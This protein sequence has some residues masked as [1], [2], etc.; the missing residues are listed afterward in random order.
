[1]KR[2]R[3]GILG[4]SAIARRSMI[5]ALKRHPRLELAAVG[6]RRREVRDEILGLGAEPLSYDGLLA[7]PDLDALYISLPVGLHGEYAERALLAGK[8]VLLEKTF[9]HSLESAERLFAL[10]RER[11][12][13]LREGLMYIHHPLLQQVRNL[14]PELGGIRSVEAFFGF[15]HL[16][17]NDIRYQKE[18]GGGAALDALIYPLSLVLE[19]FGTEPDAYWYTVE[20]DA[21]RGVDVS[22]AVFM[23]FGDASAYVRYGFGHMYRNAYSV[24]GKTGTLSV[25]RGFSRPPDFTGP[26]RLSRQGEVR[27]FEVPP[28]DQFFCLLDSFCASLDGQPSPDDEE[29]VLRR[30]RIIDTIHTGKASAP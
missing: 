29:A 18:L 27:D 21:A 6:T 8:H 3:I 14:L 25:D 30:M 17:D 9:T 23:K 12:L 10:S 11:G 22:G 1:M 7:A 28:A 20:N 4:F 15:P 2:Y 19:L 26:V 16:P 24:W 5:P 13:V